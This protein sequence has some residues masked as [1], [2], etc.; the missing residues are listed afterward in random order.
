M[1][2]NDDSTTSTD[3]SVT[4]KSTPVSRQTRARSWLSVWPIFF[5]VW[6]AVCSMGVNWSSEVIYLRVSDTILHLTTNDA[7][8]SYQHQL[9]HAKKAITCDIQQKGEFDRPEVLSWESQQ[10][11]GCRV[12]APPHKSRNTL[13]V[14]Y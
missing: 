9:R 3:D 10:A 5:M 1:R 12:Y 8:N 6:V 13:E 4:V 7:I 14:Y 2:F 11:A